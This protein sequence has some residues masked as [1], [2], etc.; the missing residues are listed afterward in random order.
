M[1]ALCHTVPAVTVDGGREQAG[2]DL[3]ALWV[4]GFNLLP[5]LRHPDPAR[6]ERV[7]RAYADV[8]LTQF[9]SDADRLAAAATTAHA[10]HPDRVAAGFT[11]DHLAADLAG[12]ALADRAVALLRTAGVA[13][14][15]AGAL[16][17]RESLSHAHAGVDLYHW[18]PPRRWRARAAQDDAERLW[19]RATA[20]LPPVPDPGAAAPAHQEQGVRLRIT[21]TPAEPEQWQAQLSRVRA[22]GATFDENERCWYL[23]LTE[24]RLVAGAL[25]SL[26]RAAAEY[27]T[28]VITVLSSPDGA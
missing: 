26:F 14:D 6:R 23:T 12:A 17:L 4:L 18:W 13:D 1:H 21:L 15:P 9:G 24:S 11:G 16:R 7:L 2:A 10:R 20:G 8:L 3:T 5:K 19:S 22:S 28:V 25:D 27:R